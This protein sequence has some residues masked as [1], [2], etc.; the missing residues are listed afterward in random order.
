MREVGRA[1]ANDPDNEDARR[2]LVRLGLV[3]PF[4]LEWMG[5][6]P[7]TFHVIGDTIVVGARVAHFRETPFL[8]WFFVATTLP[9]TATC[10]YLAHVRNRLAA[11]EQRIRLQA[12]QLRQILPPT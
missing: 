2:V 6:I 8:I 3:L 10:V 12:W 4:A 9:A 1:L 5:V 11:A 7:P